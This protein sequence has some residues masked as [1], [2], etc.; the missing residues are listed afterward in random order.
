MVL[1]LAVTVV[2]SLGLAV[3]ASSWHCKDEQAAVDTADGKEKTVEAVLDR[4]RQTPWPVLAHRCCEAPSTPGRARSG[5]PGF[6]AVVLACGANL[7][8]FNL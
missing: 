4:L 8:F 2:S 3:L 1:S 7:G 5:Q 6:V